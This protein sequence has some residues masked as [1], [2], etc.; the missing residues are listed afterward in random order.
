MPLFEH[1]VT[2]NK[3]ISGMLAGAAELQPGQ[4]MPS[5]VTG[6][7]ERTVTKSAWFLALLCKH[8]DQVSLV[9]GMLASAADLQ[10]GQGMSSA[11]MG[12]CQRTVTN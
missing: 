1:S 2:K 10:P 5:A 4:S 6:C 11:V 9:S 7:C 8:Y 3:L 12:C